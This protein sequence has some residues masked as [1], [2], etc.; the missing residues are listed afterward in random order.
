MDNNI[1]EDNN[2]ETQSQVHSNDT[3]ENHTDVQE[4]QVVQEFNIASD[5]ADITTTTDTTEVSLDANQNASNDEQAMP[6]RTEQQSSYRKEGAYRQNRFSDRRNEFMKD[7]EPRFKKFR[8]YDK[9][10]T[11]KL[12]IDYKKPHIL[13][14]FMTG[15]GKILSAV[16]TGTSS[17]NQRILIRE[18]KRAR[19]IG[20]LPS[21]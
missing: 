8:K 7:R 18:I 10:A 11:K 21:A 16:F 19:Y 17:K 1:N 2:K 12:D 20:L 3:L 15:E 4:E 9:I 13:K 6:V 14:D 5:K